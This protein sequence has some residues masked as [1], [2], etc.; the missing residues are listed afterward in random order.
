MENAEID[1]A[2]ALAKA[3]VAGKTTEELTRL[4]IV[5]QALSS[6]VSAELAS[7]RLKASSVQT[8]SGASK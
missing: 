7:L 3:L 4:Q 6:M 5:L 1:L 8:A 2:F